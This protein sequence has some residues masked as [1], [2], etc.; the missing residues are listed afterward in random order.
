MPACHASPPAREPSSIPAQ[1]DDPGWRHWEQLTLILSL[2][3]MLLLAQFKLPLAAQRSCAISKWSNTLYQ[4][5][6]MEL[7]KLEWISESTIL[8]MNAVKKNPGKLA[9]LCFTPFKVFSSDFNRWNVLNWIW[10]VLL[11]TSVFLKRIKRM[12]DVWRGNLFWFD[13]YLH[14]FQTHPVQSGMRVG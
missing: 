9:P 5:S 14:T 2:L 8:Y 1:V 12:K 10:M 3:Y 7:G 11:Q 6:Y 13:C 4:N